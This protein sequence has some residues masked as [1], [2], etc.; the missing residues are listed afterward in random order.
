MRYV[1]GFGCLSTESQSALRVIAG[2]VRSLSRLRRVR[3]DIANQ[4]TLSNRA[5]IDFADVLERR[6]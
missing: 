4:I 2:V 1:N 6:K 3:D 5:I